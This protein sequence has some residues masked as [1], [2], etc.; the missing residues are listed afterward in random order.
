MCLGT[1][2][3]NPTASSPAADAAYLKVRDH[4]LNLL[5]EAPFTADHWHNFAI[6]VGWNNLT[7]QAFYSIDDA[8]LEAVT[9]VVSNPTA[10]TGA[11]GQGDFHIAL[12]K[13]RMAIL[14]LILL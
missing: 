7:L 11:A 9:S 14:S 4:A 5:F 3:S 2:F 10:S 6:Q 13:V 8:D 12:L 1:P